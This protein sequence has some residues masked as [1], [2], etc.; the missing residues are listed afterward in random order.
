MVKIYSFVHWAPQHFRHHSAQ[1]N[2]DL[3]AFINGVVS[4]KVIQSVQVVS[5]IKV[6]LVSSL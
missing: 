1:P 2:D 5:L 6:E 3:M 4:L